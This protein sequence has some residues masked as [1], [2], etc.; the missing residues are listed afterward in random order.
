LIV[1]SPSIHPIWVIEEYAIIDRKFDWFIPIAPPIRAFS[2]ARAVKIIG[3]GFIIIIEI[4]TRGANFCHVDRIRH[5]IHEMEDI[6]EG[7]HIWHGAAPILRISD[8]ISTRVN[9]LVWNGNWSHRLILLMSINLDPRACARKY[10]IAPSDS[11]FTLVII[12]IGINASRL[13]SSPA[14]AY[15]QFL[16][17]IAITDLIIKRVEDVE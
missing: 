17:E 7:Y 6:T 8:I 12:I 5:G 11:W 2:P 13:S 14:Q 4:I 10:L 3:N 16:L 9:E 15:N 1:T